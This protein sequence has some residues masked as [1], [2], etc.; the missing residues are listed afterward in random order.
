MSAW[1][2]QLPGPLAGDLA[3]V[4]LG[5]VMNNVSKQGPLGTSSMQAHIHSQLVLH[6]VIHDAVALSRERSML[7]VTNWLHTGAPFCV[8]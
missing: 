5:N 4:L 2:E 6:R 3:V 1:H 7:A 8:V